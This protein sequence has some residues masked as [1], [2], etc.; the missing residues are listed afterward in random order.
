MVCFEDNGCGIDQKDLN[1]IFEP[2]FTTK[3][4]GIGLGLSISKSIAEANGAT[5][6]VTSEKGKGS[7]FTVYF[8]NTVFSKFD[9]LGNELYQNN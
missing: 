8:K 2:L 3:I 1:R 4:K 6:S 5:V 9:F 7:A